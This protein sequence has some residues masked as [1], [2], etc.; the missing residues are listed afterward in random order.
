VRVTN[1]LRVGDVALCYPACAAARQY[2]LHA[3]S[4]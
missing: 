2:C 1:G 4:G 3:V